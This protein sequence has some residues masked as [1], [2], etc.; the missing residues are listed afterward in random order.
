[1]FINKSD[2]F[3]QKFILLFFLSAIS[4]LL[5]L[6]VINQNKSKNDIDV[7]TENIEKPKTKKID[8]VE[9][10]E[11][12]KSIDILNKRVKLV[13]IEKSINDIEFKISNFFTLEDKRKMNDLQDTNL[14]SQEIINIIEELEKEIYLSLN[15]DLKEKKKLITDLVPIETRKDAATAF[16]AKLQSQISNK[17]I[18]STPE[19]LTKISNLKNS[20]EGIRDKEVEKVIS[21]LT[22][23][24]DASELSK[25]KSYIRIKRLRD[26]SL[27]NDEVN[28]IIQELKTKEQEALKKLPSIYKQEL[29]KLK[30]E[31]E[32]LE[33]E[34]EKV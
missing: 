19:L 15:P 14:K 6:V 2:R 25:N 5:I 27:F 24:L 12:K 3:K 22:S 13:E 31:K 4:L 23:E 26:P 10:I 33:K 29:E 18:Q 16:A 9:I 28:E 8:D 7:S 11:I 21:E 17:Q 32:N 20:D 34:I 30:K 1:M